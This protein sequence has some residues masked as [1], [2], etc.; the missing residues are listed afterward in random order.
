MANSQ[1]KYEK[2]DAS[3]RW[4]TYIGV[5][6]IICSIITF[7]SLGGG[8]FFLKSS[9]SAKVKNIAPANLVAG[10]KGPPFPHLEI[11]PQAK[12]KAHLAKEKQL[13]ESYGWVDQNK[14][15]IRIPIDT[16]I[17]IMLYEH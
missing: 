11:N 3:A 12:N 13:L 4:I 16:A 6:S 8:F 9:I 17:E 10:R 1:P 5:V 14:G 7:A 2:T 15:L